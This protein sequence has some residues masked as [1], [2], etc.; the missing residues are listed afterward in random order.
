MRAARCGLSP[1][2][3]VLLRLSRPDQIA[4]YDKLGG[5]AHAGLQWST[6]FNPSAA[7]LEVPDRRIAD[8]RRWCELKSAAQIMRATA[9]GAKWTFEEAGGHAPAG[10]SEQP[11]PPIARIGVAG[12]RFESTAANSQYAGTYRGTPGTALANRRIFSDSLVDPAGQYEFCLPGEVPARITQLLEHTHAWPAD[13]K[14]D[15]YGN[16]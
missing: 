4:N 13:T 2:I 10:I 9:V 5:D 12:P 8:S 3:P 6:D 7:H 16:S 15:D 1:T 14:A 11:L